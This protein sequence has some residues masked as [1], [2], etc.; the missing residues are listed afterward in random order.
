[1][2]AGA[3]SASDPRH[4]D[5][6]GDAD[7]LVDNIDVMSAYSLRGLADTSNRTNWARPLKSGFRGRRSSRVA[8]YGGTRKRY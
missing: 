7:A 3:Q 2:S 8:L 1:M 4:N 5:D 6:S